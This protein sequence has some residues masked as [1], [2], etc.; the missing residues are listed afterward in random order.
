MDPYKKITRKFTKKFDSKV[1]H[2]KT[3]LESIESVNCIQKW[4]LRDRSPQQLDSYPCFSSREREY[5]VST[6]K[7]SK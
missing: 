2:R 5:L 1:I 4:N 7:T 3:G 6:G